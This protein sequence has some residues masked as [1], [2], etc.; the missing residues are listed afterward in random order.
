LLGKSL[1]INVDLAYSQVTAFF[2][3]MVSLLVCHPHEQYD[4]DQIAE[5]ESDHSLKK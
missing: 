2:F 3:E 5:Q 1:K 4:F